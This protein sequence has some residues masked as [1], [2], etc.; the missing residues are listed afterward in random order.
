MY[1]STEIN[2]RILP[3]SSLSFKLPVVFA[4]LFK[5]YGLRF[6]GPDDNTFPGNK[7]HDVIMYIVYV[8]S[9]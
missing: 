2:A 9:T 8:S 5:R 3:F 6:F 7:I 1:C 4:L